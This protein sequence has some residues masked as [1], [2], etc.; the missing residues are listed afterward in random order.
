ML[1]G[2]IG[3]IV[4]VFLPGAWITFGL[5]LRGIPFWAKLLIGTMLAPLIVCLQFYIIRLLG[6]SFELTAFLLVGLNLPALYLVLKQR[7]TF[8]LPDRRTIMA[9]ALVLLIL[10]ACIA[11]LLFDTQRRVYTWEA[12]SQADVVYR[13]ADG[14]LIVEDAELAGVRLSYPWAGHVYQA[15]LS[16]LINSPPVSNYIW[17]NLL[18]LLCIFC[19]AGGIVTELGGNYLSGVTVV[20]AL[21]FGVNFVGYIVGHLIPAAFVKAHPLLGNIWGDNRYTPWLDKVAFFGQMYF[22]MGIFI[23]LVFLIIKQLHESPTQYHLA[24]I[25]LL[26]CSLGIIYPVLWPAAVALIGA[27]IITLLFDRSKDRQAG[28]YRQI[29]AL[30]MVVCISAVVTYADLKLLTQSRAGDSLVSLN[31]LW[32]MSQKVAESVVVTSPLLAGFCL[33][34]RRYWR[35]RRNALIV[36]GLTALASCMLYVL[37][38][39]PWYRNEYK[40]IFTAAICLA[41]FPS[42]A[43]ESLFDRL[44]RMALPAIGFMTIILASPLAYNT[45]TQL[46]VLYTKLGPSVNVQSFD[47]RLDDQNRLAALCD[48]IR[49]RTPINT[50]LV[51]ENADLHF[52]T[53]VRR[54]LY[55]PPFQKEPHP[56]ILITSYE[57][58]TLVKGYSRQIL[59]NRKAI[60]EGLFNPED[61]MQRAE[62]L[63]QILAFKRPVAL[64]LDRQRNTSLL[65]WL[66]KKHGRSLYEGH[67]LIL[68]LIEPGTELGSPQAGR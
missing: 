37:F 32:Y 41:P 18:W 49:L 56:G 19:F 8:W 22:A 31:R 47:L 55:A 3:F 65:E 21:S 51:L 58:L 10:F 42:L 48:A 28:T 67:G 38:D 12:W 23:A 13:I 50:I 16:Y 1:V 39:I 53:L 59:E 57:M 61:P 34:F 4:L 20:T 54:Q 17:V 5:P 27:R 52:P 30:G 60:L 11:P 63:D 25:C 33:V 68:W 26:L 29:L 2:A 62:S 24:V 9:G 14:D 45:Y 40:F 66:A 6:A 7:S 43:L 44:G 15:V 46:D 64:I 36:L 35:T